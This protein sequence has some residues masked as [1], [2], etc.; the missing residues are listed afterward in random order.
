[1]SIVT[2]QCRLNTDEET[3]R[4]LWELMVEKNT[5]LVNELNKQVGECPE[6]ETWQHTGNITQKKVEEI[7]KLLKS[8]PRFTGQP[9]RFITSACLMTTYIYESWLALQKIRFTKLAGK[10]HWLGLIEE[11]VELAKISDFSLNTVCIKASEILAQALSQLAGNKAQGEAAGKRAKSRKRPKIDKNLLDTLFKLYEA[12]EDC[13]DRRAIIH[14]LRNGCQVNEQEEDPESSALYLR[15]KQIEVERLERQLQ[16]KLPQ[17]RD[18]TGVETLKSLEEAKELPKHKNLTSLR[19]LLCAFIRNCY[20]MARNTQHRTE[21]VDLGI[22]LIRGCYIEIQRGE[23]EF[24]TWRQELIPRL[25]NLAKIPKSL[26]YPIIFGSGDDLTWLF[27]AK[28]NKAIPQPVDQSGMSPMVSTPLRRSKKRRKRKK[29]VKQSERIF[30]GFN[31]LGRC[32]LEIH[33]DRRQLPLLRQVAQEYQINKALPDTEKYSAGL[34]PLRSASLMWKEDKRKFGKRVSRE[35]EKPWNTHRLFLHCSIET[36]LLSSEGTEEVR[37]EK[38]VGARQKLEHSRNKTEL[39]KQSESRLK[40]N[41]TELERLSRASPPRPSKPVYQGQSNIL[42]GVS[43]SRRLPVAVAIV[44]ASRGEVIRYQSVRQLLTDRSVQA[45]KGQ[46]TIKQLRMKEYRLLNRLREQHKKTCNKE[47]NQQ[48]SQQSW[49]N[50]G[51]Y[52]DRLMA[53]RIVELA[54]EWKAGS[55]VLPKIGDVRE[56]I[57]SEIRAIAEHKYPGDKTSQNRYAKQFRVSFHRWS[58]GRLAQSIQG[59]AS[60]LGIPIEVGYQPA[61]GTLQHKAYELA[62]S[63]YYA[64]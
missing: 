31:G 25:S 6:F 5:P 47:K 55:I 52:L 24:E 43:F 42:V 11:D 38:I 28:E 61:Q 26:P 32:K 50:L 51:Q 9:G 17:P 34:S 64:R 4:P 39:T 1:M 48:I 21:S 60:R 36:R 8:D 57:E 23:V 19:L 41:Q 13:L 16:G 29:V 56:S 33:C 58:Y 3:R 53:A 62:L 30:V 14:L 46:Q 37:Q 63:A 12:T 18:P 7:C 40:A 54:L 59:C 49:S 2:I 45:P 15:K 22:L 44:D 27:K 10:K 35:A 20:D